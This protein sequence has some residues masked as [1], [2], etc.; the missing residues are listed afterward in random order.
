MKKFLY[1]PILALTLFACTCDDTCDT[2]AEAEATAQA[3]VT[4][5]AVA[6]KMMTM[7]VSGMMCKMNCGGSIKKA[8]KSTAGVT[9]VEIDF[10]DGREINVAKVSYDSKLVNEQ[11]M[12]EAV[13][14]L[15]DNQYSVGNTSVSNLS[16][17]ISIDE[18]DV[19][20]DEETS[21]VEAATSFIE[22]P[23]L[24]DLFRGL[25]SV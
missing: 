23:N 6:D 14:S 19:T 11:Q 1:L 18:E 3:E 25:F 17:E 24:M 12:M 15:Y 4:A 10:E 21:V 16:Q 5:T 8:L 13:T 7:E 9:D 22:L 20:S 2:E